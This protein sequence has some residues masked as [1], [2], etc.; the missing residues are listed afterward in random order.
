[1]GQGFDPT[2]TTY[3]YVQD[4]DA[5]PSGIT[6]GHIAEGWSNPAVGDSGDWTV[7]SGSTPSSGT[8]P[9]GDH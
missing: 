8:G 9:S 2:V 3:P 4:F 7:R 1:M 6:S 5:F